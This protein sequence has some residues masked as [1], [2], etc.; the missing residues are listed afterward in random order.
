MSQAPLICNF[1]GSYRFLSN[2]YPCDAGG[3]PSV[4]H[5]FQAAKTDATMW[6]L[7]IRQA[8]T[9]RDAKRLGR[10]VPLR[11]NWESIKVDQMRALLRLKFRNE[12][13]RTK[14]LDTGAAEL[15]EGN[16]WCDNFW[17]SCTCDKCI[18]TPK[19]NWL[20][21]LLMEVREDLRDGAD[22]TKE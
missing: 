22:W 13:L 15:V 18:P 9:A 21:L 4:E 6:R 16:R 8:P 7:R 1:R 20:G 12:P 14:L 5:A 19:H 3:W 10:N 11:A 17:G 2:F